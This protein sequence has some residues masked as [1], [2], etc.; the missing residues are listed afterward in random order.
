M[1]KS[2]L[3]ICCLLLSINTPA[4]TIFTSELP[5][6]LQSCFQTGNCFG[7]GDATGSLTSEFDTAGAAAFQYVQFNGSGYDWKWLMRY[8][9]LSPPGTVAGTT[10]IAVQDSYNIAVSDTH[11]FTVYRPGFWSNT[12]ATETLW[13]NDADLAD[14]SA[15]S[16]HDYGW[17]T[18][19]TGDLGGFDPALCLAEGCGAMLTLNLLHMNFVNGQFS[20]NADDSR[21]LLY[22]FRYW[23]C[24]TGGSTAN[25][26]YSAAAEEY[27]LYVHA[28]PLP[29]SAL[30]F[31]SGLAGIAARVNRK[32]A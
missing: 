25:C 7:L 26:A 8:D 24:S 4:A 29:A 19:V 10:W 2:T 23:D 21:A 22:E 18:M 20:F 6:D 32:S 15:F 13:V 31:M 5:T 27:S 1:R 16:R 14:G 3:S 11:S 28:V 30:L 9:L 17:P 12:P